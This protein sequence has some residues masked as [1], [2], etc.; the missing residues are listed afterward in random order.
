M[1]PQHLLHNARTTGAEGLSHVSAPF[2]VLMDALEECEGLRVLELGYNPFGPD[3]MKALADVLKY[4]LQ[5]LRLPL[6][7]PLLGEKMD[8][9]HG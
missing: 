1:P 7:S 5:V 2:K 3:G 6:A 9:G 4:K 8:V